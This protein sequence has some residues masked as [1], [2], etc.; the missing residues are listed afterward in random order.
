[1]MG[2][3]AFLMPIS[4]FRFMR[5]ERIDFRVVLGLTVGGIPAVLVA[6]YVVK[7]LPLVTL[8]WGVV[9]VVLYAAMLLLRA[10][11]LSSE[12][13]ASLPVA[14]GVQKP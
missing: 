12:E 3:C 4:G 11:A 9:A 5:A 1:M 7:S 10:A 6:A 13:T 2:A 14:S 8:R